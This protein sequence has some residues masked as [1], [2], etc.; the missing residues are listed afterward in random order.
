MSSNDWTNLW[1]KVKSCFK[2]S[3]QVICK[4]IA[5]LTKVQNDR[6][7]RKTTERTRCLGRVGIRRCFSCGKK[8]SQSEMWRYNH[9]RHHLFWVVHCLFWCSFFCICSVRCRDMLPFTMYNVYFVFS[10]VS[11]F[12]VMSAH[13]YWFFPYF[14]TLMILV[15]VLMVLVSVAVWSQCSRLRG[16]VS[17][18]VFTCHNYC[19]ARLTALSLVLI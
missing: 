16:V 7:K 15:L 19:S 17:L 18:R 9:R 14:P 12:C 10:S 1:L 2:I 5:A 8:H 13:L 3:M 11:V 4:K 6:I